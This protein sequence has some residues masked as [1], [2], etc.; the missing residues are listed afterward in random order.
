MRIQGGGCDVNTFRGICLTSVVSKVLC[1][2]LESRLSS[3]AEE[4]GL[5]AEEQVCFRRNRGCRDQILLL[6]LLGQA[7]MVKWNDGMLVALID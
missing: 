7:E 6:V 3:M 2:I 5:I 1:K 4:I